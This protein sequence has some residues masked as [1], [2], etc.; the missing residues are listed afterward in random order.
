M[1]YCGFAYSGG[2]LLF[3]VVL[4]TMPWLHFVLDFLCT[5]FM[6]VACR[7]GVVAFAAYAA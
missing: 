2:S 7:F 5:S 6:L 4:I 1:A 3:D